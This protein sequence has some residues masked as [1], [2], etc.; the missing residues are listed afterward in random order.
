MSQLE[1]GYNFTRMVQLNAAS[2]LFANLS[3][4]A[5]LNRCCD[6]IGVGSPK[7]PENCPFRLFVKELKSRVARP[8]DGADR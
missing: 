8:A 2:L 5:P 1:S 6:E 3:L 4:A 7:F